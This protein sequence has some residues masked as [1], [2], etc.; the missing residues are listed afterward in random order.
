MELSSLSPCPQA[1]PSSP[2]LQLRASLGRPLSTPAVSR[3][4]AG[5]PAFL[6]AVSEGTVAGPLR[7]AGGTRDAL[8]AHR[9]PAH[10]TG[11][12]QE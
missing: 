5:D 11:L 3:S 1:F 6:Q 8:R 12:F 10:L 4:H 2:F 7:G 9:V